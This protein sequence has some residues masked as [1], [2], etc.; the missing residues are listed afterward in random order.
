MWDWLLDR[1]DDLRDFFAGPPDDNFLDWFDN[2][3]PED[4]ARFCEENPDLDPTNEANWD[5]SWERDYF[6][7]E[8]F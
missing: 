3:D 8:E 4:Q 1:W 7:R 2:L 6:D 5:N